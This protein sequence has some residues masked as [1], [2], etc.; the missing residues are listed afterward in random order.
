MGFRRT[1]W[2]VTQEENG[3][4]VTLDLAGKGGKPVLGFS[5]PKDVPD[6]AGK[7]RDQAAALRGIAERLDRKASELE[8]NRPGAKT[9]VFLRRYLRKKAAAAEPE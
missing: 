3:K 7:I 2:K 5:F 6:R 1:G 4:Y 8:K 9:I